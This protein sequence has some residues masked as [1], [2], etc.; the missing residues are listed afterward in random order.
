MFKTRN[1][2]AIT[3]ATFGVAGAAQAATVFEQLPNYGNAYFADSS[4]GIPDQRLADNFTLAATTT[5]G[6]VDFW[7][8]YTPGVT[9][10]SFV[11]NI[12]ADGGGLPGALLYSAAPA[13]VTR[14]NTNTTLGGLDLYEY[15]TTLSSS[16]V[17]SGGT[18]YFLSVT[19]S[20]GL[21]SSGGWGWATGS[22]D[23]L[24]TFSVDSGGSWTSFAD[25][26]AF[27]LGDVVPAPSSLALV[28]LAGL[29]ATRRRR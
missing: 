22:G 7:G 20:T 25:N 26:Q 29:G 13:S 18:Q 16:F 24:D 5:I 3:L 21:G 1:V 10:D 28:G 11:I 27:R 23:S 12:Y 15:S 14:V 6:S 19:N 8:A 4:S 2:L 9:A 17:A